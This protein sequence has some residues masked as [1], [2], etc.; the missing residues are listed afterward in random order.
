MSVSVPATTKSW[1][2]CPLPRP[3]RPIGRRIFTVQDKNSTRSMMEVVSYC[4]DC[5]GVLEPSGERFQVSDA[6]GED[7]LLRARSICR[8]P[9]AHSETAGKALGI[10]WV[11]LLGSVE[12]QRLRVQQ[13]YTGW[14]AHPQNSPVVHE[15]L[16]SLVGLSKTLTSRSIATPYGDVWVDHL[17]ARHPLDHREPDRYDADHCSYFG[18][19][20]PTLSSPLEIWLAEAKPGKPR[21]LRYLS[22]Y[23]VGLTVTTYVVI[24]DNTNESR[25]RVITA[26]RLHDYETRAEGKRQGRPIYQGW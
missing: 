23:A 16:C 19:I 10:G 4:L 25:R 26:Y 21:R 24:V 6:D 2:K 3:H 9:V 17:T 14:N 18:L 11:Q 13:L 20:V 1:C 5:K 15:K 22:G 7:V 8:G 12:L